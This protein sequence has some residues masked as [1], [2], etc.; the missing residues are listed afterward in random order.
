MQ[1]IHVCQS[2]L[3][4]SALLHIAFKV[5]SNFEKSKFLCCLVFWSRISGDMCQLIK[6]MYT[7]YVRASDFVQFSKLYTLSKG[8]YHTAKLKTVVLL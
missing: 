1:N 4:Q 7:V 3:I 6:L 5:C 2:E 8:H